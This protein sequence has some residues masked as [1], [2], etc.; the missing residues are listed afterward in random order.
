[1]SDLLG[2]ISVED[3]EKVKIIL[4]LVNNEQPRESITL[5]VFSDEYKNFI[6]N[7]RSS[8]Y[9][10]SVEI[11]LVY[12]DRYFG[13]ERSIDS[14]QYK[15]IEA[16]MIHLQK[17]AKKGNAVYFRNLKAAFN[18]AKDWGYIKE[19]HFIKIKLPKRQKTAPVF[20]DRDRL[21]AISDKLR[22][23]VVKNVVMLA[24]NTGMRLDEIVNLTWKNVDLNGRTITVGDENYITKGR[25]QRF[26]PINDEML[27]LLKAMHSKK[28][29][30][31][32]IP[33]KNDYVFDKGVNHKFTGDY[34]SKQ[35]KCACKD[36]TVDER[37]HFHSLRHSFASNLAQKGVSLYIIKELLG[38][39][40]IATTEIYAHL[41]LYTLREA[42]SR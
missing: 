30:S 7:N 41:N 42:I 8:S 35:F 37:I 2:K 16:F 27:K 5:R 13:S 10:K 36:A 28:R 18:K 26:I 21:Q 19:N 9:L 39:S 1:M 38:H 3:L 20:L 34:F 6:E 31:K 25:T 15:D 14:I 23:P 11:S 33:I 22:N 29:K 24:F 32:I 12:L 40:A 4:S 17:K